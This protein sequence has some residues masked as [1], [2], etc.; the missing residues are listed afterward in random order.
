MVDYPRL[1]DNICGELG[2]RAVTLGALGVVER[3]HG[4][5]CRDAHGART[6]PTGSRIF[7]PAVAD[8]VS[9]S[10]AVSDEFLGGVRR[11]MAAGLPYEAV[12]AADAVRGGGW[13]S[14][15]VFARRYE[16][17]IILV[18][19]A[20]S[21]SEGEA[22]RGNLEALYR[23][24]RSAGAGFWELRPDTGDMYIDPTVKAALGYADREVR[25]RLEAWLALIEAPDRDAAEAALRDHLEGR[26]V[27]YHVEQRMRSKGGD[28]RWFLVRGGKVED[29]TEPR[30]M[31]G[32][33]IDL[34]ARKARELE[35]RFGDECHAHMC[36]ALGIG[37]WRV[38]IASGQLIVDDVIHTM[39]GLDAD[40]PWTLETVLEA[41]HPMDSARVL[42]HAAKHVD[43]NA[44]RDADGH[45]SVP[46]FE[47]RIRHRDGR[48]R[49]VSAIG[50]IFRRG[51]GT[52]LR[53]LGAAMDV[54]ERR[55]GERVV[56]VL[57]RRARLRR[58]EIRRLR[59]Q[60]LL[61]QDAE[62]QRIARELH[63]DISQRIA[64]VEILAS[65]ARRDAQ[66]TS[67]AEALDEIQQRLSELAKDVRR[68]SHAMAPLRLPGA[69]LR[70]QLA[71]YGAELL[72]TGNVDVRLEIGE[73]P[74]TIPNEIALGLF[75]VAQE[76]LWN[77]SRHARTG[78]ARV[79]LRG[80]AGSLSLEVAD[81]GSGFD[82]AAVALSGGMGLMSMKQR[83]E[84]FGGTLEVDAAVGAG[85]RILASV[86][87]PP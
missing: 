49:R 44:R 1:L 35:Q 5:P 40:A 51:D 26:A 61:A 43:A 54:T 30:R 24:A 55:H 87:L 78:V 14:L 64:A 20:A 86:P 47:F 62:R 59:L 10:S 81:E 73:L 58:G 8:A 36:R 70:E 28:P 33:A 69:Y 13:N 80:G 23:L 6:D 34:T 74:E 66:V 2:L 50:R 12:Y 60:L 29:A 39:L 17:V 27:T 46:V 65:R 77:V 42:E 83:V 18:R 3:I 11:V 15:R 71:A 53:F 9:G 76:A 41:I 21:R 31:I 52:P 32:L 84:Q 68:M 25:N 67:V 57:R 85:T 72:R 75:R 56:R 79:L 45:T 82:P 16:P 19:R 48:W 37:Q 22:S 38:E 7:D 63:D 4:T